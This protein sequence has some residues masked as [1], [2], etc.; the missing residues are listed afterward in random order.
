MQ[1]WVET[2]QVARS[3]E[4]EQCVLLQAEDT[5]LQQLA[6]Q[7]MPKDAGCRADRKHMPEEALRA[8]QPRR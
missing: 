6:S 8:A 4:H 2:L 7:T 3:R 1:C 5:F